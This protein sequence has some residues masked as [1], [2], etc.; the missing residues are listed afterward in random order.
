VVEETTRRFMRAIGYT[1]ILDIGYRYDARDGKYKL[2][3]VNPRLGAAFRLFVADNGLDVVRALYLDMTGQAVPAG[4]IVP[5]RK[6]F[7]ENYDLVA[8][9]KYARDGRLNA[10]GW[11]T[12][13]RGVRESA[14]FA[15]DDI[16][17]FGAMSVSSAA[18]LVKR[19]S[20]A[21]GWWRSSPPKPHED[22]EVA[23][24]ELTVEYEGGQLNGH[25]AEPSAASRQTLR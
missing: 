6:W 8:S 12:S 2:L 4:R 13:F 17:P 7:V 18:Y 14:W 24:P 20:S 11:I 10:R 3:D 16:R 21:R 23:T 25:V 1:G 15:A 22:S 19:R 5:G 9:L